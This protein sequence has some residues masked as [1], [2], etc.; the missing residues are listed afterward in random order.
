[1]DED[2]KNYLREN[3]I[4]TNDFTNDYI[5]SCE[6][7]NEFYYDHLETNSYDYKNLLTILKDFIFEN[8]FNGAGEESRKEFRRIKRN[9]E[10]FRGWVGVKIKQSFS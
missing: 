3:L 4:Q 1:M 6:V 5:K 2:F 10:Q 9:R 7:I 8:M